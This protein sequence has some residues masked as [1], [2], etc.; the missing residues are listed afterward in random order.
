VSKPS[1]IDWLT[2]TKTEGKAG[3]E[4]FYKVYLGSPI[5]QSKRFFDA[6]DRLGHEIVFEAVVAASFRTLDGDPLNYVLAVALSK[7]NDEIQG[8]GEADRYKFNLEKA[9]QRVSLQNEELERKLEKAREIRR[10]I[11]R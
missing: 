6:V 2:I 3:W 5:S 4:R 7:F 8:I 1:G 11:T 10:G 9:K